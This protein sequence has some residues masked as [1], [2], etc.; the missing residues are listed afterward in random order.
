MSECNTI[1]FYL[2]L[3]NTLK[4]KFQMRL[5]NKQTNKTA[6]LHNKRQL[7]RIS[8]RAVFFLYKHIT[9]RTEQRRH[10]AQC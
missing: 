7:V 10:V 1:C 3:G 8:N 2:L 5:R 4:S 9:G 6:R